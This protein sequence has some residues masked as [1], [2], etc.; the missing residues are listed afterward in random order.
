M[1]ICLDKSV[2]YKVIKLIKL[3]ADINYAD[4]YGWSPLHLALR[5]GNTLLAELLIKCGASINKTS[6]NH[7]V[8]SPINL[9]HDMGVH[10]LEQPDPSYVNKIHKETLFILQGP[11]KDHHR[12]LVKDTNNN[13]MHPDTLSKYFNVVEIKYVSYLAFMNTLSV[14]TKDLEHV[15]ILID[16]HGCNGQVYEIEVGRN[17]FVTSDELLTE[18]RMS[19]NGKVVKLLST[20]C[21]G[22]N[23]HVTSEKQLLP[24]GSMIITLSNKNN[25]TNLK[26]TCNVDMISILDTLLLTKDTF[27]L[28][29]EDV[30]EAYCLSQRMVQNTPTI[31]LFKDNEKY[32]T[33]LDQYFKSIIM[34]KNDITYSKTFKELINIKGLSIEYMKN[35]IEEMR[36]PDN[37]KLKNSLYKAPEIDMDLVFDY[38]NAGKFNE[39]VGLYSHYFIPNALDGLKEPGDYFKNKYCQY[40]NYNN[41]ELS[42]EY[43]NYVYNSS[44]LV[45]HDRILVYAE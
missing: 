40:K 11:N 8:K 45:I 9:M 42:Q 37:I 6:T 34:D 38:I 24:D 29:L 25:I 31:T 2:Q 1:K 39:L 20:A 27:C 33:K 10:L 7:E 15:N 4:S 26:D 18:I 22:D 35:L 16:A 19:T 17:I 28:N 12:F 23:L 32:T 3:G 30:L 13:L 21:F 43:M 14:G 36:V 41:N 5:K 44:P